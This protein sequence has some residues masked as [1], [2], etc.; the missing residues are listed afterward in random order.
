MGPHVRV[1]QNRKERCRK[2]NKRAQ[3]RYFGEIS[4]T[5][6]KNN[7]NFIVRGKKV[8]FTQE[9]YTV[10]EFKKKKYKPVI[11]YCEKEIL[12]LPWFQSVLCTVER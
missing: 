10:F 3:M 1:E 11:K 4:A 2:E 8:N 7:T 9:K 5:Q 6:T 12:S